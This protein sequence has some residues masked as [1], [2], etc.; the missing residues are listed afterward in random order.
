MPILSGNRPAALPFRDLKDE[1]LPA[2]T[3]LERVRAEKPKSSELPPAGIVKEM[4]E[5]FTE[6]S[7]QPAL[8]QEELDRMLKNKQAKESNEKA[9]K[10]KEGK[11]YMPYYATKIQATE[12]FRLLNAIEK[13]VNLD[14]ESDLV[15]KPKSK[16]GAQKNGAQKNGAEKNGAQKDDQKNGSPSDKQTE[17]QGD[18]AADKKAN[19]LASV[20]LD[21]TGDKP[22]DKKVDAP[23]DK[24]ITKEPA[25]K[26]VDE[27]TKKEEEKLLKTESKGEKKANPTGIA[28]SKSIGTTSES[29]DK[30]DPTKEKAEDPIQIKKMNEVK[31]AKQDDL[32]FI[33]NEIPKADLM[34]PKAGSKDRF[35]EKIK[36]GK[37]ASEEIK[38]KSDKK[39]VDAEAKKP[40]NPAT[41]DQPAPNDKKLKE[42]KQTQEK[43]DLTTSSHSSGFLKE[44]L[45]NEMSPLESEDE[46]DQ[47]EKAHN[48]P[49]S[50][51]ELNQLQEDFDKV[52]EVKR[53]LENEEVKKEEK[54]KKETVAKLK[55]EQNDAPKLDLAAKI[56]KS[57][58]ANDS[59]PNGR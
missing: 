38:E 39:P 31:N 36:A 32:V 12:K 23:G 11:K 34:Y 1:Q 54:L 44:H 55:K 37:T 22:A 21:K 2:K 3:S 33:V 5:K 29:K 47:T 10:S 49:A 43:E 35:A 18:T 59:P 57:A 26:A 52:Q 58:A 9:D 17:R 50:K 48:K 19:K 27:P 30:P 41:K 6:S 28:D 7:Q 24:Q 15:E 42:E 14:E 56:G 25:A 53:R 13:E 16:D 20:D 40:P 51:G 8:N 4:Q 45:S 46:E